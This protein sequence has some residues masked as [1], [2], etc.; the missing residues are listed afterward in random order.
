MFLIEERKIFH[1]HEGFKVENGEIVSAAQINDGKH[2]P[3]GDAGVVALVD[4]I[5]KAVAEEIIA[6]IQQYAEIQ[7]GEVTSAT[8]P[9][10]APLPGTSPSGAV[11]VFPANL[12]I[13]GGSIN[14][15]ATGIK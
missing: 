14:V 5:T 10:T 8:L 11:S 3:K 13:A 7:N 2:L 4:A 12:I 9:Y 15:T 1:Y 6:H